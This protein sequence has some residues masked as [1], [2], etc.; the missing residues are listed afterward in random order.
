LL[1]ELRELQKSAPVQKRE[2]KIKTTPFYLQNMI[3]SKTTHLDDE[4]LSELKSKNEMLR[5]SIAKVKE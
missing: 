4:A 3:S 1:K 5:E 2:V